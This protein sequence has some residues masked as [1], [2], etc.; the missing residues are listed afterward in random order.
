MRAMDYG[1]IG[2]DNGDQFETIHRKYN[3]NMGEILRASK[4]EI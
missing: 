4:F 3:I 2:H 1:W